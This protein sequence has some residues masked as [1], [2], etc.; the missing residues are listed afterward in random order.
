MAELT[1]AGNW[2]DEQTH[3]REKILSYDRRTEDEKR[4]KLESEQLVSSANIA[5]PEQSGSSASNEDVDSDSGHD[6]EWLDWPTSNGD[7]RNMTLI[8]TFALEA[9]WYGVFNRAAAV[10]RHSSFA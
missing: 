8:P 9:E 2:N 7:D 5:E 4:R 1:N 3:E 10:Y 6:D